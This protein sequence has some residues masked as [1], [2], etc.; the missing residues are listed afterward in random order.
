MDTIHLKTRAKALARRLARP[1]TTRVRW[2][3]ENLVRAQL[4][5]DVSPRLEVAQDTRQELEKVQR[6]VPLLLNT[7]SSQNASSR[8]HERRIR[9][10]ESYLMML[11][12]L[13]ELEP[14]IARI[15]DELEILRRRLD[16]SDE[17][18]R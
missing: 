5:Q 9:S 11:D 13:A 15:E 16:T 3:V 14:R 12:K 1:L 8:D 4:A 6:Y 17:E 2:R 18:T 10:L 7:I